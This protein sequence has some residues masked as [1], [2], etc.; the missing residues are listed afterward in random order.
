M[1]AAILSID[2]Q[3]LG[4]G[5]NGHIGFNEPGEFFY[6]DTHV[7][8][9]QKDTIKANSRFFSNEKMV[10]KRSIT[11]GL[12]AIMNARKILLIASG[13]AKAQA[14]H[15]AFYGNI[16]PQ[17]PASIL[18]LHWDVTVIADKKAWAT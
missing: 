3:L 6:R 2:L 8:E 16:T 5:H 4:I 14:L 18:Q 7:V 1:Y 11:M 15:E 9:L 17:L 10:P 12:S 13:N